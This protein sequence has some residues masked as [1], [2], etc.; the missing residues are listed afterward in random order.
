MPGKR[1]A[2]YVNVYGVQRRCE[3]RRTGLGSKGYRL[4][5]RMLVQNRLGCR[6]VYY[7]RIN[8]AGLQETVELP[9]DKTQVGNKMTNLRPAH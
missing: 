1:K 9:L 8:R 3:G 6:L 5:V 2:R 7:R 4:K